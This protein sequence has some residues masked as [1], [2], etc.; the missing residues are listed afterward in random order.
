VI[1]AGFAHG[2]YTL[3]EW[4]EVIYKATDVYAPEWERTL[5]WNDPAV[6]IAWP[7]I[8]GQLPTLS[9]K[10]AAGKRLPEAETFA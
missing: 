5:A 4:A 9:A 3:S 8:E 7:L 10:D 6:A 2:F 1:P